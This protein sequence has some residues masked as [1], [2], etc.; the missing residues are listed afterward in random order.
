MAGCVHGP[1]KFAPPADEAGYSGLLLAL[2]EAPGARVAA[3]WAGPAAQAGVRVGD[4]LLAVDGQALAADALVARLR[5]GRV[6]ERLALTIARDGR[7]WN[8][9]LTLARADDWRGPAEALAARPF[10]PHEVAPPRWLAAA[11][12][13]LDHAAPALRDDARRLARMFDE[14]AF[15]PRG[16]NRLPIT[17]AALHDP[18]SALGEIEQRLSLLREATAQPARL[19][20]ALCPWFEVDCPSLDG[21]PASADS[22]SFATALAA[23]ATEVRRDVAAGLGRP[24]AAALADL[25]FLAA[26]TAR[27]QLIH[28]QAE[29]PRALR[30]MRDSLC[31]DGAALL[32]AFARL[33]ALAIAAPLP[34]G[35]AQ[36]PPRS[37]AEWVE[38]PILGHWPTPEGPVV[39]GARGANRYRMDHL[40]AVIDLDG[41]DVY[42][43]D[44]G[45][46]ASLALVIDLA[47]NDHYRA[48]RGGP[49]GAWLGVALTFDAAGDDDYQSG[50]GGCG[51]GLY[52]VG[53]L[54]DGAGRDRYRC[55]AWSLGA[56]LYGVGLALDR[57]R[58]ADVHRSEL[59]SQGVG[60]PAGLGVLVDQ[61]GSDL[62]QVGG[63]RPSVYGTPAVYAGFGQGLGYG[64]RPFDHGGVGLLLDGGGDDRYEGGEFTQGGGYFGG[65]GVLADAGGEDLYYGQRYAQG[66]A[67]HQAVGALLDADGDDHYW[68]AGAAAQGAAWDQGLALLYDG[69]GDDDY[70]GGDLS[71]GAA[72]QQAAALLYDAAGDDV[73]RS[74]APVAQG[75]AGNND[76][77]FE[78]DAPVASLG[79]LY[80]AAGD[81]RYAAGLRAGAL[82]RR[83]PPADAA[84]GDGRVGVL[85]DRAAA[86][87]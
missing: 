77:H 52:G 29:A 60:G 87:R 50:L 33:L 22:A 24:R 30:A 38:G 4:R 55:D 68:T 76:Y 66:F 19:P 82:L 54:L 47:G 5:A 84:P 21:P 14:L 65:L 75:A 45:A 2:D 62:Y 53:L 59:L 41:D 15:D 25:D 8:V 31:F 17:R 71:Q 73:Y 27:A 78:P 63:A 7:T 44:D 11:L 12:A 1:A 72:A 57:G 80:D 43:W 28:G 9:A 13:D 46:A 74:H 85:R 70:R 10:A 36:A 40:L 48:R 81:D 26:E 58:D 16:R 23:L 69:G 20:A 42:A 83:R 39:F 86:P 64:L 49:G 3:V 6:A 67:A 32:P 61:G 56:G 37:L 79:V 51:A 18:A 35:E 34:A